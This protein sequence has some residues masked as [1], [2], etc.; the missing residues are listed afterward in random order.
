LNVKYVISFRELTGRG[1]ALVGHFPEHPS[2]LYRLDHFVP[3]AYI[4]AR[5]KEEKDPD[6]V[7]EQLSSGKFNPLKEVILERP[8]SIDSK[9]NFQAEAKIVHYTNQNVVIKAAL[10]SS[11]ILVLADS[12]YPGWHVYVDGAERAILRANLFFR[13]VPLQPGEHNVEFRYEPRS[14]SLG[15]YI[16][17]GFLAAVSIW[18]VFLCVRKT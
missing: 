9:K 5:T 3:R 8:F 13:G 11:G 7:V 1:L 12:Y 15:L 10:N 18:L 17:L 14:F 4:V 16:S 6:K 2:W